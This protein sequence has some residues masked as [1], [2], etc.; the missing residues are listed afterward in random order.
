M[1]FISP[2]NILVEF[3]RVRLTDPRSR[4]ETTNTETFDGGSTEFSI[5]APSGA[6]QCVTSV[7]VDDVTQAKYRD[8]YIDWQNEKIIFYSN[9]ASGTDNVE[10]TYKYGSTN[11]IFPDKAKNTLAKTAFPRLNVLIVGGAGERLGQY[12]SD[13]ETQPHFQI[14]IWT[15]ENQDFTIDSV[16]YEGDKLAEYIGWKIMAAFRSYEDDL[17]PAMYNY[18][19]L[20]IPRDLGFDQEMESFHKVVEVEMK[21]IN[22]SEGYN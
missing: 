2:K 7:V 16:K 9:T 4:A 1:V 20:G 11:W 22:M 15:K 12:N 21:G 3:L 13:V 6:M 19:P 14:D 10:I 8:Y 18:N 5:S 17:H